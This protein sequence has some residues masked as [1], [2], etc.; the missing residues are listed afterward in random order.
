MTTRRKFLI[1]LSGLFL[2]AGLVGTITLDN[3]NAKKESN[4]FK[5][6]NVNKSEIISVI[7]PNSDSAVSSL[8]AEIKE[9]EFLKSK[10]L[11]SFKNEILVAFK[12]NNNEDFVGFVHEKVRSDFASLRILS[13]NGWVFSEFECL[14]WL[15]F[16]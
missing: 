6:N 10:D 16:G 15:A 14:L 13:L 5:V 11:T 1:T 9:S 3:K 8:K 4:Q 2:S 12:S 7:Y